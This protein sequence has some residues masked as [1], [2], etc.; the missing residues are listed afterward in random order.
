MQDN[1]A[2]G[3]EAK[4]DATLHMLQ[5][6]DLCTLTLTSFGFDGSYMLSSS[7]GPV[8]TRK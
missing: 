4:R 8:H 3:M 1:A 7:K 6:S 5:V 2:A